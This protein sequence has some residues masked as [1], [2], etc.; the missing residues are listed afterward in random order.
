MDNGSGRVGSYRIR[1][2][3]WV[4]DPGAADVGFAL[5]DNDGV[6]FA[7]ELTSGDET[8]GSGAD[9]GDVAE[10]GRVGDWHGWVSSE[11]V[12][13]WRWPEPASRRYR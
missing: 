4:V 6:S 13:D 10:P 12:G 3:S 7:S 9:N 5:E 8:A 1:L 2:G 11:I